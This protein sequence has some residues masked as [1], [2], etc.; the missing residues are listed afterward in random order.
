MI[1]APVCTSRAMGRF[2]VVSL[3]N[4][5]DSARA[6]AAP[7]E[8]PMPSSQRRTAADRALTRFRIIAIIAIGA[9][10]VLMTRGEAVAGWF[11]VAVGAA[12]SVVG[13]L[14]ARHLRSGNDSQH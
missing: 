7:L 9:G 10:V 5:G 2:R 14:A 13:L 6:N 11:V 3:V 4:R 8:E 1:P 12:A